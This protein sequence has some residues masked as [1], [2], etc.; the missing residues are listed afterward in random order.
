MKGGSS[1]PVLTLQSREREVLACVLLVYIL[2]S[3]LLFWTPDKV[4]FGLLGLEKLPL[5]QTLIWRASSELL[6]SGPHSISLDHRRPSFIYGRTSM[7][8]PS[9]CGL[10][11]NWVP[12]GKD[13]EE[14][15]Q[16]VHLSAAHWGVGPGT[17]LGQPLSGGGKDTRRSSTSTNMSVL[18]AWDASLLY[19]GNSTL[20]SRITLS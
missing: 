18:S 5:P 8:E 17:V 4:R 7:W 15:V 16:D 2:L 14:M 12:G 20:V 9:Q 19:S 10:E 6:L 1:L 3:T 11:V 13:G